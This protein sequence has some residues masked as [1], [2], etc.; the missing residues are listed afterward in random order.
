MFSCWERQIAPL[1]TCWLLERFQRIPVFTLNRRT[2][3][4]KLVTVSATTSSPADT[5]SPGTVAG[6]EIEE[7]GRRIS[8][9]PGFHRLFSCVAI[10][11]DSCWLV[12]G[13]FEKTAR[14]WDLKRLL[15]L[16]RYGTV[17][18]HHSVH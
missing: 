18:S 4:D 6:P 12:A 17:T 15:V 11:P 14:L 1:E 5:M 10:N 2:A 8:R 9:A 16:F 3:A 7:R 13:S